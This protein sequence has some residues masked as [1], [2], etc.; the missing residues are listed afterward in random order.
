M[1]AT[2]TE[3][4]G[5]VE[6][7]RQMARAIHGVVR[8]CADG[9]SQEESLMKPE[10]GGNCLHWVMGHL[11]HVY[12]QM[13]P[14]MGQDAVME[15]G[16]TDRFKQGAPALKDSEITMDVAVMMAAWDEAA[17][18]VDAGLAELTAERLDAKVPFSP[19][20]NPNETLRT[21]LTTLF[22]H[23]AYHAGQAGL[24]RRMVGKPGAIG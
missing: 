6:V 8:R 9:F 14:G 1:E 4:V 10:T 2:I 12:D 11:L 24:L 16:A 5:E 21:L 15:T 20:N 3:R 23:Q 18:R 13:L 22:F 17:K 7:F 19:S